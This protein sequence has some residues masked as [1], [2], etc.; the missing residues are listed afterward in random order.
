MYDDNTRGAFKSLSA[1]EAQR[2]C[3]ALQWSVRF[4]KLITRWTLSSHIYNFEVLSHTYTPAPVSLLAPSDIPPRVGAHKS[5]IV[6]RE[7]NVWLW[8]F[9][10]KTNIKRHWK[11]I[12]HRGPHTHAHGQL[13]IHLFGSDARA[14]MITV[15]AE[16]EKILIEKPHKFPSK[17]QQNVSGFSAAPAMIS[18]SVG[19]DQARDVNVN[20]RITRARK[21]HFYRVR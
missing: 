19:A 15:V 12:S 1:R 13:K 18:R 17:W 10:G 11:A 20:N 9:A 16:N 3:S 2:F 4:R 14:M 8:W 21:K 6:N 7:A 5:V